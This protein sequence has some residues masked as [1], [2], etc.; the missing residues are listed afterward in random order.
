M[1]EATYRDAT[2]ADASS[3]ALLFERSFT[4]TFG[5]LYR[6]EDLAAFL[7]EMDEAGELANPDLAIRL[8][9]ADGAAVGFAKV[10]PLKLPVDPRG[11]SVELRQLYVLKPWQGSGIAR[12]LMAWVLDEARGRGALDL[13]LTVYVDNHRARRFYEGYGFEFVGPYTFMVGNH[14]DEDHIMRLALEA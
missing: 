2:V 7:G 3:L 4:E 6:V 12:A 13:Y 14:A 5:H 1:T 8:A 9:E 11:P 10:G